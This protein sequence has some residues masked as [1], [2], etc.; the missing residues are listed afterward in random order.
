MLLR[1]IASG[2]LLFASIAEASPIT[3]SDRDAFKLVLKDVVVYD[4][5]GVEPVFDSTFLNWDLIYPGMT[6]HVDASDPRPASAI[7]GT[8]EVQQHAVTLEF[9]IARFAFGFDVIEFTNPFTVSA[10][11]HNF[12]VGGPGFWGVIF[13]KGMTSDRVSLLPWSPEPP[14]HET[15]GAPVTIDN[16]TTTR[17]P[18]PSTLVLFGTACACT[19]LRRRFLKEPARQ[20]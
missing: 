6:A 18:E 11:G 8:L 14:T 19:A 20:E 12:T 10:A 9:D 16:L 7:T 4:F 17:V 3:Y 1:L 5:S 15:V 13:D 2:C